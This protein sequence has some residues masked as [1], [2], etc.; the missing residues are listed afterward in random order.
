VI[1]C[2]NHGRPSELK[3]RRSWM[4]SSLAAAFGS[5]LHDSLLGLSG[6]W[7]RSKRVWFRRGRRARRHRGLPERQGARRTSTGTVRVADP[8][9][10]E[11]AWK[12]A[13]TRRQAFSPTG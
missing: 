8:A 5:S 7:P 10:V 9:L 12:T 2:A 11:Q 13:L 4:P 3:L 6:T 1:P